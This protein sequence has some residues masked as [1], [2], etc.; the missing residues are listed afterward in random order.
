MSENRSSNTERV[1][2]HVDIY[3]DVVCPWCYVGLKR[4]EEA[5]DLLDRQLDPVV[6]WRPF[7]LN[8]TMPPSGMDRKVYLEA[9]FGSAAAVESML[10]HVREAG[11][12]SGLAFAFD[13]IT[14]TPNTLD[15]HRLIWLAGREGRQSK[16]AERLFR[17]YFE[18]GMDLSDRSRLT[19]AASEAGLRQDNVA[20]WLASQEGVKEV[21]GEE[22]TG[23]QLGIRAVPYFYVAGQAGLSGAHPPPVIA[24][25]LRQAAMNGAAATTK[26]E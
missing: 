8:P 3:S 17:G 7:E 6:T 16:M 5:L 21:R 23:L 15:A 14:R 22:Q 26:A 9:K 19:R 12:Q 1:D 13:R 10:D 2:L 24:D 4:F 11:R 25:W 20:A 18:E